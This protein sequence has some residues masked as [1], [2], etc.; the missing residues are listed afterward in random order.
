[1]I[2]HTKKKKKI[3]IKRIRNKGKNPHALKRKYSKRIQGNCYVCGKSGHRAK[4]YRYKKDYNIQKS[5]SIQNNNTTKDID[6]AT[7]IT[8]V[9]LVTSEKGWWVDTSVNRHISGQINL[10]SRFTKS[11]DRVMLGLTHT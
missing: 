7:I 3:L 9:D 1:M 11:R 8:E 2:L 10:F 6:L 4:N 5:N